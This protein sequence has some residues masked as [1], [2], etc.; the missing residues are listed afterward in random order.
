MFFNSP[1][2]A[3]CQTP[4]HFIPKYNLD[5]K[6]YNRAKRMEIEK[7][8]FWIQNGKSEEFN[9]PLMWVTEGIHEY[10]NGSSGSG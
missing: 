1:G 4:Y 8:H 9:K 7:L 2:H 5:Q 6:F 10:F 3:D